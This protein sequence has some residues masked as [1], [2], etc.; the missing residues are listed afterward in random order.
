M[1][2]RYQLVDVARG[3]ALAAMILY[4]ATWFAADYR[5]VEVPITTDLSWRVFQKSIASSFFAL[6]GVG[7]H[8]AVML[9]FSRRRYLIRLAKVGGCALVVTATSALLD[10]SRLTTFGILHAITAASILALPLA[11]APRWLAG[12][13]G[14]ALVVLG[15]GFSDPVFNNPWLS[16]IGLTTRSTPTFDHQPLLPW[17]GVVA[18]GVAAGKTLLPDDAAR[19]SRWHSDALLPRMLA[20]AGRHSL[21]IYMGHVPALMITMEMLIRL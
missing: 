12:I 20:R 9:G 15:V 8:L 19:L 21:L 6:V 2:G 17:L 16:W 13:L 7:L 14:V 11:L 1:A 3:C 5:L 4:H 10:P 18:L